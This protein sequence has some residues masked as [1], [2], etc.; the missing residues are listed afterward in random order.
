MK[1][2]ALLFLC[3]CLLLS[4]ASCGGESDVSCDEYSDMPPAFSIIRKGICLNKRAPED[5]TSSFSIDEF[6]NSLGTDISRITVISLP[7]AESGVLM[8]RGISVMSGQT[9][10]ADSLSYLR[11]VPA[12]KSGKAEFTFTCDGSGYGDSEVV[13]RLILGSGVNQS[14]VVTDLSIDTY[15]GIPCSGVLSVSDPEN[16]EYTINVISYP[17]DGYIE[18]SADGKVRYTPVDGFTGSDTMLYTATDIFGAE[19]QRA[20]LTFSV[21]KNESGLKFADM[22]NMSGQYDAI[23]MCEK[24]VMVYKYENGQYLFEPEKAVTKMEFLVMLMC[25]S[26]VDSSVTAAADTA[27]T[28]DTL[29]PTGMKGFL[30]YAIANGIVRLDSGK[31]SPGSALNSSDAAYMVSH[32]LS[33]PELGN[34]SAFTGTDGIPDWAGSSLESALAAGLIDKEDCTAASMTKA[35]TA[36]LLCRV[37]DY[38]LENDMTLG[39]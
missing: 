1:K 24:N 18:I 7:E 33:L 21:G 10:P 17:S 36:R 6:K 16:D 26:G 19:S 39:G 3:L 38:M 35:D 23:R 5:G 31:F 14:P 20:T 12:G 8:F 22:E 27:A 28:D 30:A 2:T 29:L 15:Q 9:L 32:L 34:A 13:C 4:L 37:T 25:A 11:F